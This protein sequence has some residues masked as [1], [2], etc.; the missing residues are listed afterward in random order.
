MKCDSFGTT[1]VAVP[2]CVVDTE[3]LEQEASAVEWTG[4]EEGE[5]EEYPSRGGK[6]TNK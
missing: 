3:S 5:E 4:E 1:L 6:N 2:V